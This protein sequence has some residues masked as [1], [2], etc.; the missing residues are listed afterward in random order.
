MHREAC[1]VDC[2]RDTV[3]VTHEEGRES[4][5]LDVLVH[6]QSLSRVQL[7]ATPWPVAPQALLSMGFSRQEYWGGLS[8]PAPGDLPEPGIEPTPLMS[9][10]LA[11]R[12]FTPSAIWECWFM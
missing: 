5:H 10:E 12:F 6:A 11:G 4:Q 2:A 8:C 7:C 3:L 1:R 9:S